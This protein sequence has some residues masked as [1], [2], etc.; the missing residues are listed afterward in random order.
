MGMKGGNFELLEAV[1]LAGRNGAGS[2]RAE[3][4]LRNMLDFLLVMYKGRI[5]AWEHC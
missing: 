1:G 5:R 4:M 2:P 3:A